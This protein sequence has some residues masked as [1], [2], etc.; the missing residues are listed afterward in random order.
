M[1]E[2]GCCPPPCSRLV[3]SIIK[4]RPYIEQVSAMEAVD[5]IPN[6]QLEKAWAWTAT[7]LVALEH[8]ISSENVKVGGE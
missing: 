3:D 1:C 4:T 2:G 5:K 6:D 8:R 7:Y